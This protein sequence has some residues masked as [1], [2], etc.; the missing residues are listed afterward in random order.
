M[1]FSRKEYWSGLPGPA[2]EDLLDPGFEPGSPT[3]QANSLLSELP[4]K[5]L[6]VMWE[7]QDQSLSQED[8]LEKGIATHSSILT[9]RIPCTEE[10]GGLQSMERQRVEHD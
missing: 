8:P 2:P 7:T 5:N 9:W 10:Q 1:E 4:G 3:L 6:P